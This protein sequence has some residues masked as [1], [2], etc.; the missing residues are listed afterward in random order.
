MFF[1]QILLIQLHRMLVCSTK[2]GN[3][4]KKHDAARQQFVF[5]KNKQ[6]KTYKTQANTATLNGCEWGRSQNSELLIW[7]SSLILST[8][9]MFYPFSIYSEA[10]I[11][12]SFSQANV[13]PEF[14]IFSPE[15]HMLHLQ[16]KYAKMWNA[17][18]SR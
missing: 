15:K 1:R 12:L 8:R 14:S 17:K 2:L 13:I 9:N 3:F 18:L 10:I 7:Y 16:L 5:K 11:K 4:S 6:Q